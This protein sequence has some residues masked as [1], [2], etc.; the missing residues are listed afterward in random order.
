MPSAKP[1]LGENP[2]RI[3]AIDHVVLW[4][5]DMDRA[6][7][8]YCGVL[9]C[10]EERRL[11]EI[12]L[13]QLRAGAALIDLLDRS[14]Q[15]DAGGNSDDDNMDHLALR[16]DDFNAAAIARHLHRHGVAVGDVAE[17]YGAKGTGPSIYIRDPDGNSIEL[18]GPAAS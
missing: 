10:R 4:V 18:K 14:K 17:R 11:G 15:A 12:G 6:L 16:L 3:A 9:G 8:F 1:P 13:V 5:A 2:I 7:A